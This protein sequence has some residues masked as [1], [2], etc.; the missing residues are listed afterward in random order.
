MSHKVFD[1]VSKCILQIPFWKFILNKSYSATFLQR[2]TI[3]VS[4]DRVNGN[5][6][7]LRNM[8]CSQSVGNVLDYFMSEISE[9]SWKNNGN[10]QREIQCYH[11]VVHSLHPLYIALL[12]HQNIKTLWFIKSGGM[13][14]MESTQCNAYRL[15]HFG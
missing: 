6:K 7:Y 11:K 4:M 8:I 9:C 15:R 12:E 3:S 13:K 10:F 2:T 5:T 14:Y 1:V